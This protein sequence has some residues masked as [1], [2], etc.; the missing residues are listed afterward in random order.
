MRGTPVPLS[1]S[2]L[3]SLRFIYA[4]HLFAIRHLHDDNRQARQLH[5][6][7]WAESTRFVRSKLPFLPWLALKYAPSP[8]ALRRLFDG[9]EYFPD[10]VNQ[11]L[12]SLMSDV[13][14]EIS[15]V[16]SG[17]LAGTNFQSVVVVLQNFSTA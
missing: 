12:P 9:E 7:E 15:G 11:H 3:T 5:D 14:S 6:K 2:R 16:M 13:F 10:M 1:S 4:R 17:V 8:P